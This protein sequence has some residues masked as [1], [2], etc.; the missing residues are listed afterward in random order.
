M[1]HPTGD[2]RESSWW[3]GGRGIDSGIRKQRG[4]IPVP[5][6]PAA[7]L[8]SRIYPG[9]FSGRIDYAVERMAVQRERAK[10]RQRE[11][12]KEILA[13]AVSESTIPVSPLY[14]R[15]PPG[16]NSDRA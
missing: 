4:L 3:C 14:R 15:P 5:F 13:A 11:R 1:S 16:R 6:L 2:G 8:R 12:E 10:E 9:S 7:A